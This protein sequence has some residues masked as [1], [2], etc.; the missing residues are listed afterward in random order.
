ML[1]QVSE[2]TMQFIYIINKTKKETIKPAFPA[3]F[4]LKKHVHFSST[5]RL[6]VVK[7]TGT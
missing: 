5:H 3:F 4:G 7:E 2:I 1:K 6:G